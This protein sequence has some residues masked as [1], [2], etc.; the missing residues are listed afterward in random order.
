MYFVHQSDEIFQPLLIIL[1]SFILLYSF[2]HTED[3]GGQKVSP[4]VQ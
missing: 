4:F 1:V 2:K 3:I